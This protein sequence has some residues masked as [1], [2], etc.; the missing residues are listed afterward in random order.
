M[1]K[2]ES[3]KKL[4]KQR[5]LKYFIEATVE[6]IK[7]EGIRAITI[8]KVADKAGYNSAT[9][10]NYF[11]NLDHLIFLASLRFITP[12]TKNL[13]DYVK[14]NNNALKKNFAVW[15]FFFE[16]SFKNP[17][18]YDA[19]FFNQISYSPINYVKEYY[20][21]YPQDLSQDDEEIK[22]ILLAQNIYERTRI[23]VKLCAEENFIKGEDVDDLTE[24]TIFLYKGLLDLALNQGEALETDFLVSKGMKYIKLCYRGFLL[25]PE[26][27][28]PIEN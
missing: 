24:M 7:E 10:Y 3:K 22:A 17:R 12:Y 18:I 27:I 23:L 5:I 19:I 20:E 13:S 26:L 1:D 11:E 15:E 25:K 2:K 8:R 14:T 9:L 6:I 16:N 28:Q 4:Q 21:L